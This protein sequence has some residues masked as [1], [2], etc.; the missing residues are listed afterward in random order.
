VH[1]S[2]FSNGDLKTILIVTGIPFNDQ[3]F[4]ESRLCGEQVLGDRRMI[5][6]EGAG[7]TATTLIALQS[8]V[9]QMKAEY[10]NRCLGPLRVNL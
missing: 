6:A 10:E 5:H 2:T 3:Y 4:T 9:K 7:L 8:E 1:P